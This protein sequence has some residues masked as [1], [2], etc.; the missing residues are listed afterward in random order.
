MVA[1]I[2]GQPAAI[3]PFVPFSVQRCLRLP[4]GGHPQDGRIA[5]LSAD[6]CGQAI[7]Q[8]SLG[9]CRWRPG[10]KHVYGDCRVRDSDRIGENRRL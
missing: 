4:E 2:R 7:V 8:Q 3:R 6:L 5:A 10:G 9:S 1:E